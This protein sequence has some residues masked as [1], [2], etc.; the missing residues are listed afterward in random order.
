LSESGIFS[1]AAARHIL[2]PGA[3]SAEL[4][5]P[6]RIP[7]LFLPCG[8]GATPKL[9]DKRMERTP[10]M[11]GWALTFLVLALIAGLLGFTGIAA[12]AANIAHILFVIFLV[13]FVV[14][15]VTRAA[16]GSRL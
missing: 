6:R 2:R 8:H 11:L 1:K 5:A 15:L 14:T 3:A 16:R 7:S 4:F 9:Q 13:L 12:T 10:V